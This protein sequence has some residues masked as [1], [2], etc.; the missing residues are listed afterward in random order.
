MRAIISTKANA[1]IAMPMIAP[2]VRDGELGLTGLADPRG[3]LE[4]SG[5]VD[6]MMEEACVVNKV[7]EGSAD[8][9]EEEAT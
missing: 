8:V 1:P 4:G 7:G 6:G 5:V 3:R 2:V 9:D